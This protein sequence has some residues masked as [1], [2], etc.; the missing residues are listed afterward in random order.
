[1][2]S[3]DNG[4]MRA[5]HLCPWGLAPRAAWRPTIVSLSRAGFRY[6]VDYHTPSKHVRLPVGQHMPFSG[7]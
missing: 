4:S 6:R 3:I 2:K 1:M 7:C 5:S